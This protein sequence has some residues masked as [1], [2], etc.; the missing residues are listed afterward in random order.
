M[1]GLSALLQREAGLPLLPR[2]GA[3]FR[4]AAA[5][6][7]PPIWGGPA[8]TS[9]VKRFQEDWVAGSA[10]AISFNDIAWADSE[11]LA[12]AGDDCALHLFNSSTGALLR[13]FDA[14]SFFAVF[15]RR[16]RCTLR[17]VVCARAACSVVAPPS[18]GSSHEYIRPTFGGGTPP[19]GNTITQRPTQGHTQSIAAVAF[20]PGSR[21]GM[22]LSGGSDRQVR[23]TD[24]ERGAVK[25]FM[26]HEARVRCLATVDG[27][28]VL[29]GEFAGAVAHGA[30]AAGL[31]V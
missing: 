2:G 5:R 22:L 13:S 11:I 1:D 23:C 19:L 27:S 21:G 29:S 9:L 3:G 10:S 18:I 8:S 4:G 17:C 14:V 20:V 12:T 16:A 7:L 31:G 30:W 26:C 25:P 6:G 15:A 28:V 24:I